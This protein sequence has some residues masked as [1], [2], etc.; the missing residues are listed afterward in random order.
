MQQPEAEKKEE[1]EVSF[2][3]QKDDDCDVILPEFSQPGISLCKYQ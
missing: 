2:S 1:K 3:G